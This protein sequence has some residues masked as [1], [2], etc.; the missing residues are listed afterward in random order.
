MAVA[1]SNEIGIRT[2]FFFEVA[3]QSFFCWKS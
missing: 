2:S 3:E 1:D